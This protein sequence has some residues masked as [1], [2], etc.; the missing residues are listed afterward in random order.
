MNFRVLRSLVLSLALAR[1]AGYEQFRSR[2]PNGSGRAVGISH[3]GDVAKT[4]D[5]ALWAGL[6]CSDYRLRVQRVLSSASP[7]ASASQG[8]GAARR[9]FVALASAIVLQ[10][11]FLW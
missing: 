2:L 9:G 6:N 10:A 8:A 11:L 1:A 7:A 3:P 4:A 5:P